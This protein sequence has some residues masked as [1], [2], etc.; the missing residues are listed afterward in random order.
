MFLNNKFFKF[1]YLQRI[2]GENKIK[3]DINMQKRYKIL[4]GD[5]MSIM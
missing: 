1:C 3:I 4:G 5:L 2:H